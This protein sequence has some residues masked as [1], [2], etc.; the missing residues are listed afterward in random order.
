ML[1]LQSLLARRELRGRRRLHEGKPA[2]RAGSC[3]ARLLQKA[4]IAEHAGAVLAL[5]QRPVSV[6]HKALPAHLRIISIALENQIRHFRNLALK[7]KQENA[8][9]TV[10]KP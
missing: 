4:L 10:S 9:Q 7:A 8:A 3:C 6:R 5:E 1:L 2:Q